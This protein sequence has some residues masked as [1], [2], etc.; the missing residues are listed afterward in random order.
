MDYTRIA[1]I[2]KRVFSTKENSLERERA[3][4]ALSEADRIVLFDYDMGARSGRIKAV[5]VDGQEEDGSMTYEQFKKK[6]S[7]DYKEQLQEISKFAQ[8]NPELYQQYRERYRKEES[9]QM[10][11]HN[12]RLMENKHKNKPYSFK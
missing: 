3:V 9:E 5:K 4:D 10:Q 6:M 7:S 1:R 11:L 2:H 8:S 12:R